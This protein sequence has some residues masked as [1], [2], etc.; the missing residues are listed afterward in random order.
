MSL[1]Q[2]KAKNKGHKNNIIKQGYQKQNFTISMKEE[3][4]GS[5]N[6]KSKK[7]WVPKQKN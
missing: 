3:V 4:I 1:E 2:R 7:A 6:L 5:E